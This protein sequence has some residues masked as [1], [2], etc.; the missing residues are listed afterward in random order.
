MSLKVKLSIKHYQNVRL[1][2]LLHNILKITSTQKPWKNSIFK[3]GKKI[4]LWNLR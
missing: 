1:T 2:T 3:N 4:F